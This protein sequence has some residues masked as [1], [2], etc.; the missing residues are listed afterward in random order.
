M[1]KLRSPFIVGFIGASYV[2]GKLCV[3]TEFM[4]KGSVARI[5]TKNSNNN[6]K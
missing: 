6:N 3:L 2:P 1:H 5:F 4:E